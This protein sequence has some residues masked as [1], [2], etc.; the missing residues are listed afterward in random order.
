MTWKVFLVHLGYKVN[1][2]AGRSCKYECM[3]DIFNQ[4]HGS[5]SEAKE[6]SLFLETTRKYNEN[7]FNL[8]TF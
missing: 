8:K 3:N 6:K 5:S 4:Q 2:R 1:Q 7:I